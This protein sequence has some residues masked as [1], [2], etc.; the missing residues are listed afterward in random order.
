MAKSHINAGNEHSLKERELHTCTAAR[1]IG[2]N[3]S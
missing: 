2:T 1:L 3:V